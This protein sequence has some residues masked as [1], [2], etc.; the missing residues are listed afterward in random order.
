MRKSKKKIAGNGYTEWA[1][2]IEVIK[3][4]TNMS[5]GSM[6]ICQNQSIN[7]IRAMESILNRL[8]S[9]SESYAELERIGQEFYNLL[10]TI[11]TAHDYTNG[12]RWE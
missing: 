12:Y 3:L 10:G 9:D 7:A 2:D 5:K 1:S 4:A 6:K 8:P 11:A